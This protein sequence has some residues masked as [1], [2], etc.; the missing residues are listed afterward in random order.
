M[1]TEI[2]IISRRRKKYVRSTNRDINIVHRNPNPESH[3]FEQARE[4]KRALNSV[5]MDRIF[6]KPFLTAMTGHIDGIYCLERHPKYLSRV[7]SA[8]ADGEIR[9][10]DLMRRKTVASV[11]AH[12]QFIRGITI[13]KP[14]GNFFFS[15]SDDQT[16][17][18]WR[19]SDLRSNVNSEYQK[20]KKP[21][22]TFISEETLRGIDHHW[23]RHTFVTSG[24][25]VQVWDHKRSK[26]FQK[27]TFGTTETSSAIKFSPVQKNVFATA[28]SDRS[29]GLY[30]LKISTPIRKVILK[31]QTNAISWNPME[32]FN[33]TVANEDQ[34]CYTFDMRRLDRA[35]CIHNGHLN[36]VMDVDYSPTGR[37]FVTASYDHT[38]RIFNIRSISSRDVYH[39]RRMK[40]VFVAKYSGDSKFIISA[41]DDM[42]IRLWKSEASKPLLPV[43]RKEKNAIKYRES[44]K[45]RYGYLP[46]IRRISKHRHLPRVLYFMKQQKKKSLQARARKYRNMKMNNPSSVKQTKMRKRFIVKQLK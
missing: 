13:S 30:D 27:L 19:F 29:V 33:F 9:V 14:N 22:S 6:A 44:L 15:C 41:S 5:K 36:A 39:T 16:I 37:E 38:I 3:P 43:D 1:D 28:G 18:Q 23:S 11:Q 10:W 34:N 31:N 42:N 40:R 20:K 4:Y 45:K 25:T 12:N 17:K 24:D 32:A 2:K 46:E 35:L 21:V 26:P 8:S 7:V